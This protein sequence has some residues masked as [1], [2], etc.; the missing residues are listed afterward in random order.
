VPGLGVLVRH[1]SADARR[2]HGARLDQRAIPIES[3]RRDMLDPDRRISRM[4]MRRLPLSLLVLAWHCSASGQTSDARPSSGQLGSRTR[5]ASIQFDCSPLR[6]G[7]LSCSFTEIEVWR[8]LVAE[9][10]PVLGSLN[11]EQCAQAQQTIADLSGPDAIDDEKSDL[12]AW[13]RG[14]A[15][16]CESGGDTGRR[17]Y[18]K[19]AD[20]NL[21]RSCSAVTHSFRQTFTRIAG[22]ELAWSM[23]DK[24][25][26]DCGI[27]RN[28]TFIG[29]RKAG[30]PMVW[31]YRV[32]LKV[33]NKAMQS[34][35]LR[36]AETRE[37]DETYST[38]DLGR[39]HSLEC[40]TVRFAPMCSL[41]DFPCLS[42][43]PIL[44]E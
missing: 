9:R 38:A 20:E 42:G 15:Q 18:R 1:Q 4:K 7:L 32:E 41:D 21:R 3:S 30:S 35:S 23:D 24:P 14:I 22:K 29:S 43:P 12:L 33:T 36:C 11:A 13:A 5:P 8:T 27:V 16:D 6:N 34:D 2:G 26:G 44:V 19:A 31:D 28:A 25:I 39:V 17:A 37:F 40:R 10:S